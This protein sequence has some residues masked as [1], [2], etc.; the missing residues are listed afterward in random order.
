MEQIRHVFE[1]RTKRQDLTPLPVRIFVFRSETEFRPFQVNENA[2]GYYQAGPD[3]DYI[4]MQASGTDLYR[5]VFHEYVH[6]LMRHAGLSVPVW[7]NEGTAEVYSTT[8]V[9]G[10]EIRIGDLIPAHIATLR[11][12]KLLDLPVLLA[13]DHTSPW[14]NE[15]EKAGIFYAQSWALVHMLN[16]SPEYQ[17]GMPNFLSMLFS[18][19]DPARSL[20]QAFGKSPAA[21]LHDLGNYLRRDRFA[22]VRFPAAK[23]AGGQKPVTESVSEVEAEIAMAELLLAL[24]RPDKAEALLEKQVALHPA[25]PGLHTSLAETAV[26]KKQDERA[27]RHYQ[28]AMELGSRSGRLRYDYALLLRELKAPESEIQSKLREAVDL[29]PGLFDARYLLGY[30]LL[31]SNEPA[32]AIAHLKAAAELQPLNWAVWEHLALAHHYAGQRNEALTAAQ[33]ARKTASTPEQI[34]RAESTLKLVETLT[35]AIVRSEDPVVRARQLRMAETSAV[36]YLDGTLTQIDCLGSRARL[37]VASEGR[38]MFLLVQDPSTV[39]LRNAAGHWEEFR[40]GPMAGRHVVIQYRRLP[41]T[42]Y[43]TAGEVAAIEFR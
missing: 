27:R 24:H 41:N 4:A 28:Q 7:F 36:A 16:F 30:T 9:G 38:K 14:Y 34:E 17:P 20:Q 42:T 12:E 37:H 13:V 26:Q 29:E 5:V 31:K 2:A 33:R 39:V 35:D 21:V 40:C 18:G 1:T 32:G 11:A 25:H 43:G 6:L 10:K 19:E 23:L 3:H 8:E 22:G 15:R